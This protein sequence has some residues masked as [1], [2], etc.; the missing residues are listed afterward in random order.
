MTLFEKMLIGA[1]IL[2]V[3]AFAAIFLLARRRQWEIRSVVP[4]FLLWAVVYLFEYY[5]LGENSY[6]HM[7][8]E[9]DH[10]IPYV[11]YL[12]NGHLG[13]QF[14]HG[15]SGGNDVYSSFSPGLQ[16]VSPELIWFSLFPVW[17]AILV[18]KAIIVT[19]GF[20]GAYLLCRR[21]VQADVYVSAAV[22]ALFT[23]SNQY[24]IYASYTIGSSLV[25]L[26]LAIYVLVVRSERADYFR[27]AV[28][29]LIVTAIYLDPTHVTEPMFAGLALAAVLFKRI[30][31]KVALSLVLLFLA[32]LANWA[33]PLYAMAQMAA[34]TQRGGGI[35][36]ASFTLEGAVEA[37]RF[38]FERASENRVNLIALGVLAVLWLRRD[39][40]KW[41]ATVSLAGVFVIYLTA[42]L[43]PWREIGLGPLGRLSHQYIMLAVAGLLLAPMARA[44]MVFSPPGGGSE[45]LGRRMGPILVLALAAGMLVHFKA[46]N[47][48]N[49]L[50]HGG[51]SQYYTV[52][53]AAED[54]WRPSEPFRVITLRVRDLGPEPG[55]AYGFYGHE[56]LD[57]YLMLEPRERSS[58]IKSGV[59]GRND[60]SVGTDPRLMV[61]WSRWRNGKYRGIGEQVSLPLLRVANVGFILSPLPL[62]EKGVR[63]IAG[64][65]APPPTREARSRDLMGYLGHRIGRLFDFNDLYV[66]ALANPY[67]Q[68]FAPGRIVRVRNGLTETAFIEAVEKAASS[69]G[70]PVVAGQAQAETLGRQSP[71]FRVLEFAKVRDGFTARIQSPDGGVV[72]VNTVAV[73]FWKA[74]ADGK[75]LEI[76]PVNHIQMAVRVPPGAREVRFQYRRPSVA[77]ALRRFAP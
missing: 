70:F 44:A 59:M 24:L 75:P 14:G 4:F 67:P 33:E 51:Q 42:V 29:C 46:Y 23:V 7:D 5:F 52:G 53:A 76:V 72:A 2:G 18:H 6:I 61:D 41:P 54:D 35:E 9:G 27:Y 28:P 36:A 64:P 26:P 19:V 45:G 77:D 15:L 12:L 31:F 55:L 56:A 16:L 71:G 37:V 62:E 49:L 74:H 1:D 11:M 68:V 20:W 63:L 40:F 10:F 73:P 32:Q 8:D 3:I 25:F 21:S 30:N 13:G 47:F 22:A 43:F 60:S 39:A 50:Y 34:L 38:M 65:P 66:Y 48:A 69:P 17:I 57:V 58:F